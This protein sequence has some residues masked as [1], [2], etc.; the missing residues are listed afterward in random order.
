MVA[1]PQATNVDKPPRK[2]ENSE[3][4]PRR[5]LEPLPRVIPLKAVWFT[6]P[7]TLRDNT[8]LTWATS[9]G[10]ANQYATSGSYGFDEI[11]LFVE[12]NIVRLRRKGIKRYV[13]WTNCRDSE[14]LE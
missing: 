1:E 2:R 4:E 8:T 14:P 13:A 6:H 3:Q 10:D 5:D 12:A 11:T 9:H 7:L